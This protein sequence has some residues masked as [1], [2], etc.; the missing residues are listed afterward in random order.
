MFGAYCPRHGCTVLLSLRDISAMQRDE[1]GIHVQF[2]CQC[3]Y[4]GWHHP[5]A[6][7]E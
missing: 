6:P 5:K 3:G 1:A 4:T 2:T 7:S